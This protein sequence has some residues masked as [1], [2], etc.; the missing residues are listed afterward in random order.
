VCL[1]FEPGFEAAISPLAAIVHVCFLSM[2]WINDQID[3]DVAYALSVAVSRYHTH[4]LLVA[5]LTCGTAQSC[6][7]VGPI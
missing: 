5:H 4:N 6:I 1:L 7:S 2:G 3:A